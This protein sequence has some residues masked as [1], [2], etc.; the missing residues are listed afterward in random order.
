MRR[1]RAFLAAIPS[2]RG[3]AS[4]AIAPR[5]EECVCSARRS[6]G[7]TGCSRSTPNFSRSQTVE[8]RLSR[9]R[10]RRFSPPSRRAPDSRWNRMS[11]KSRSG[12]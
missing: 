9:S 1:L 11:S 7:E 2:H 4:A 5:L 8:R 3:L 12:S 10:K 6:D